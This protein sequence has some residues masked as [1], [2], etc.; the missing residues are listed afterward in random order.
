MLRAVLFGAGGGG[1]RLYKEIASQYE[2][3]AFVDNDKRKWGKELWGIPI[4]SAQKCTADLEYDYLIITSAPG[5]D[6]IKQQ[7]L[8][9][10][11]QEN[12]I[13]TSYI[14]NPLVSR[15]IFLESFSKLIQELGEDGDCAEVGVF[16]GDFAKW[17]NRYFPD[18]ILHLFDTFEGFDIRDI[19]K[20]VEFSKAKQGDYSNTSIEMVMDKMPYPQKCKIH[21]GYF[22]ETAKDLESKFCFVNLDLDLYEPTYA[23]LN[24]FCDKITENGIILVHDYFVENFKGPRYAVDKFISET[25]RKIHKLPIGDGISIMLMGF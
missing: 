8:Q 7:C 21:K 2:V 22:P 20:E 10:G 16:E 12:K 25:E 19:Q 23:G 3:V 14:E 13:I 1:Q 24:F 18:K 11:I 17:I 15:R 6:S 9:M 5:M 4:Y